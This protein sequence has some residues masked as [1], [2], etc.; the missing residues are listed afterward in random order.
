[1]VGWTQGSNSTANLTHCLFAPSSMTMTATDPKNKTYVFVS[2]EARGNLSGC[3]YNSVA[4]DVSSSVLQKDGIYTTATGES[5]RALL[6]DGWE[7]SGGNVVPKMVSDLVNPVFSGVTISNTTAN[8]ETTYV[9][10]VGTYDPI[11]YATA[12][13]SILFLGGGNNLYYPD[14]K[15]SVTIGACRAYFKLKNGITAGDPSDPS[16]P[17]KAFVLN[18]DGEDATSIDHSPLTIDHL[19]GAWYDLGGRKLDGKPSKG[20]IY[21]H[22]GRKEV[23]K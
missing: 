8:V 19:A 4:N 23:L 10:F 17:V 20:G 16:S 2:G 12:N 15:T 18:F 14:G 3:Y 7:V 9:D 13:R 11:T 21:I 5:L 22:N 1:M 6:E